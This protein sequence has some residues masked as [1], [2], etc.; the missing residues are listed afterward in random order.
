[1]ATTTREMVSMV[2]VAYA[3]YRAILSI[4]PRSSPRIER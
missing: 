2:G 4:S 3:S 1:M